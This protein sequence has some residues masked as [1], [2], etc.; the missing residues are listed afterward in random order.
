MAAPSKSAPHRSG[1]VVVVDLFCG[2]GGFSYGAE[3]AGHR[4]ALAIDCDADALAYHRV[5]HPRAKHVQMAL[6]KAAEASLHALISEVVEQGHR[7]HVHGSP[8]CTAFS[9]AGNGRGVNHHA[10]DGMH[11]V[12]WFIEFVQEL[13]PD[14][15]SF[16]NVCNPAIA[17]YL[18]SRGV[19]HA[20]FNLSHY[21]VPQTRRRCLAGTGRLIDAMLHDRSL[22]PP[23]PT[24]PLDVLAPPPNAAY[25]RSSCGRRTRAWHRPLNVPTWCV[26]AGAKH[27]FTTADFRSIR[28]L[29]CRDLSALQ[30]FPPTHQLPSHM[31][32]KRVRTRLL[33]NAV[34]P[35]ISERLLRPLGVHD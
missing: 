5:N 3:A 6:G 10:S 29:S 33:G 9:T 13:S 24:T 19:R 12:R 8:P 32:T 35:A 22:H 7:I 25:I 34:P 16:E 20:N 21:G 30:T 26:L 28:E 23:R 2:L 18:T 31:S 1:A 15:W 11:H 14:S 4:V 27:M 17:A